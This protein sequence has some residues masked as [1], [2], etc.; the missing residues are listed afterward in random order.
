MVAGG[1]A[2]RRAGG[3]SGGRAKKRLRRATQRG[4]TKKAPQPRPA[5]LLSSTD[6]TAV[7]LPACEGRLQRVPLAGCC[8][9]RSRVRLGHQWL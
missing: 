3:W 1:P 4:L 6:R 2:G 5:R 8:L 9:V 7:A